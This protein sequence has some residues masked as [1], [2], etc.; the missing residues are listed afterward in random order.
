VTRHL[1]SVAPFLLNILRARI[2]IEL[3][4]AAFHEGVRYAVFEEVDRIS[5][6]QR[7]HNINRR[8]LNLLA[9]C[10]LYLDGL[11]QEASA[12]FGKES[13]LYKKLK[14]TAAQE[15]D[16][17]LG[18]RTMEALRNHV[19]HFDLP[20]LATTV[21][22]RW[23]KPDTRIS[24]L[25]VPWLTR[26]N[27]SGDSTFKKSVLEELFANE[28]RV[29]VMPLVRE[30]IEGLNRVQQQ[31]RKMSLQKEQAW[32]KT[33][34]AAESRYREE[35]PGE[36]K[37]TTE[38]IERRHELVQALARLKRSRRFVTAPKTYCISMEGL[39]VVCKCKCPSN[40]GFQQTDR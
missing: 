22:H 5:F 39:A 28:D 4:E 32:A 11:F 26:N 27:V 37:E 10:R 40:N 36:N 7:R 19:Q 14:T 20:I 35:C 1:P 2:Y 16:G 25:F 8:I 33:I 38:L 3:E 29:D 34:N 21:E 15:Y 17:S 23:E 31:F 9:S 13:N 30:Y 24:F 6:E 18:Y 12:I